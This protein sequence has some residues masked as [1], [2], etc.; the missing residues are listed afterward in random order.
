MYLFN[1]KLICSIIP[2]ICL[3]LYQLNSHLNFTLFMNAFLHVEGLTSP[4][5]NCT[6]Q[7]YCSLRAIN[8]NPIGQAYGDYCTAG[9]YCPEGT[10]TPVACPSGTYLPDTGKAAQTDCLACPGGNYCGQD[11]LTNFTGNLEHLVTHFIDNLYISMYFC[12][13]TP[14]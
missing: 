11:G 10:D 1:A 5:G 4:T 9:H 3:C 7:H 2:E 6:A 14:Q 8:P 13:Y 12:I